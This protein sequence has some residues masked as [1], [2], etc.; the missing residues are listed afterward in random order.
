[1]IHSSGNKRQDGT[2]MIAVVILLLALAVFSSTIS[3]VSAARA[4]A[5]MTHGDSIQAFYAAE[6]GLELS[7]MELSTNSDVDSD[8]TIGSISAV[9]IGTGSVYTTY[10]GSTLTSF[11]TCGDARRYLEV[12]TS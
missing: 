3:S 6:A 12:T 11:G 10:S 2:A 9:S 7:L 4:F 8:G 1:M 5:S